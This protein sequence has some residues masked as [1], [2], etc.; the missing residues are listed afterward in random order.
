MTQRY[1]WPFSTALP[2]NEGYTAEEAICAEVQEALDEDNINTMPTIISA[3]VSVL[4]EE[5]QAKMLTRLGWK[6]V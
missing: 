1:R 2:P 3:I 5:Q 4:T 6:L